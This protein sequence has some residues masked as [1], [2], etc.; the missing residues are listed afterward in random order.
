[1]WCILL[2]GAL[3]PRPSREL[4]VLSCHDRSGSEPLVLGSWAVLPPHALHQYPPPPC[5]QVP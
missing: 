1:M 4:S 5:P 2:P 3:V